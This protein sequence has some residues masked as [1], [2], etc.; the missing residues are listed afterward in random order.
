M[1]RTNMTSSRVKPSSPGLITLQVLRRER[2]SPT[3]VRVTL[4]EGDAD[5]FVPM[6]FDQWFRLFVPVDGGAALARLPQ[7]FDTLDYLKYLAMAKVTRPVQRN[8][9]VRAHRADGAGGPELDVDFVLH[10]SA[11]DGTAGPAATWAQACSPGDAVAIMDEGVMFTLDPT[12]LHLDLV[13]DETGLAPGTVALAAVQHSTP[14]E[15]PWFGWVVG[16]AGLVAGVRRHW[17]AG[18]QPKE[19]IMFCGYW[20]AAKHH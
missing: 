8:Y 6:G 3:Y 4:G 18:G 2:L 19:R 11:D 15:Q 10:G 5:R 20:K 9:T 16:E 14:P 17:V 13:A 12:L 7:K 1:A